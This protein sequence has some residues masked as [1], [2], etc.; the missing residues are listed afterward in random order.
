MVDLSA[1]TAGYNLAMQEFL[2]DHEEIISK[3][4][5]L[6]VKLRQ[7]IP[8]AKICTLTALNVKCRNETRWG[9][10]FRMLHRYQKIREHIP[11]LGIEYLD[12]LLPT[13]RQNQSIH[14]FC[15]ELQDF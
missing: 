13:N 9:S 5:M 8:S 2:A 3:V 11:E 7:L 6:M 14:G 4:K 12:E 15:V 10:S 1:A